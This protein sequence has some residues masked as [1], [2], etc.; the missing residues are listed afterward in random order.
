MTFRS[1][2]VGLAASL[3]CVTAAAQV[4]GGPPT[5]LPDASAGVAYGPLAI[6]LQAC[7]GQCSNYQVNLGTLPPGLTVNSATGVLSGT[8]TQSG[9]FTFQVIANVNTQVIAGG[10]F[11]LTVLP[12]A[13]G[14]PISTP[15]L[16]L[17][18]VG[19]AATGA[20]M[21]RRPRTQ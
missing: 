17:A 14:A 19:L 4:V 20:R 3:V 13:Q 6:N 1:F 11:S 8:P 10:L 18:I 2:V 7:S 5:A 21:M 9:A 15:A 16:L 12:P